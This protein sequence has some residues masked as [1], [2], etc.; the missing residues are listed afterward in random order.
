MT[1]TMSTK[2]ATDVARFVLL[3]AG[4]VIVLAGLYSF[5]PG[6]ARSNWC[7]WGWVP[8]RYMPEGSTSCGSVLSDDE[9]NGGK[10]RNDSSWVQ[11]QG[12][13][14]EPTPLAVGENW[15][16]P[17]VPG[18]NR[19]ALILVGTGIGC[20]ALSVWIGDWRRRRGRHSVSRQ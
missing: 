7:D 15:D 8:T 2:R 17:M 11:N 13:G 20:V 5:L 4:V 19:Q 12:L 3:V 16:S 14:P 10:N 6:A 9:A 18:S 1:A